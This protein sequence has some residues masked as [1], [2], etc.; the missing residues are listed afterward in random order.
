MK[1]IT[2]RSTRARR[3]PTDR[4]RHK[5]RP[6]YLVELVAFGVIMIAALLSLANAM[7]TGVR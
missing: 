2:P 4:Y 1:P 7:A 5:E 6:E 3:F